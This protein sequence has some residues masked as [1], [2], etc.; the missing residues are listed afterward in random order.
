MQITFLI[1]LTRAIKFIW[2]YYN[3][4]G[5]HLEQVLFLQILKS[6]RNAFDISCPKTILMMPRKK[7]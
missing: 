6:R 4:F 3:L 5:L 1:F 2:F 7:T